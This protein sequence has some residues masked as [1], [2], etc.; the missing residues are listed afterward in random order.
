MRNVRFVVPK[1]FPKFLMD[2]ELWPLFF[3]MGPILGGGD[4]QRLMAEFIDLYIEEPC[5]IANPAWRIT[6]AHPYLRYALP[7]AADA[8]LSFPHQ[9]AWEHYFLRKAGIDWRRGCIICWYGPES[10]E[11]PRADGQPYAR[12]TRGEIATW[13]THRMY[14]PSVRFVIGIDPSLEDE[15]RV[16]RRNFE[17]DLGP[18]FPIYSNIADT[19]RA[20]INMAAPGTSFA[21]RVSR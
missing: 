15:V 20:A 5:L 4:W 1:I 9:T 18:D 7:A 10:R 16:I 3:F 6:D 2:H 21:E 14:N 13:R 12:D 17:L 19:A 8:E 11:K